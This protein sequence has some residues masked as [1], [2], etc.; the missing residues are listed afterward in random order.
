MCEK[1]PVASYAKKKLFK[2]NGSRDSLKIFFV[3]VPCIRL[4]YDNM[5]IPK[6]TWNLS[7]STLIVEPDPSRFKLL[8][9]LHGR[10]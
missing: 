7:L 1:Q 8:L 9:V 4:T 5:V 6:I 3:Q 10:T 2:L